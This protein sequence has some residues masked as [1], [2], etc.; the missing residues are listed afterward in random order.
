MINKR[1][2]GGGKKLNKWTRLCWKYFFTKD[3]TKGIY[4]NKLKSNQNT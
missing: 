1:E 4:I 2:L 3:S